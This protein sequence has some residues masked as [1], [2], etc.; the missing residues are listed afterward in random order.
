METVETYK[1]KLDP[2]LIQCFQIISKLM[3]KYPQFEDDLHENNF[4]IRRTQL[5]P[6]LVIS[7]PLSTR[8]TSDDTDYEYDDI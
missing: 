2:K 8:S 3:H 7:D 4:M 6:Q 1:L 5:G